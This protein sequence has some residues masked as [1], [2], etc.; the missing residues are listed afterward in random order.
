MKI[1]CAFIWFFK[2][3]SMLQVRV[4]IFSPVKLVQS[5]ELIPLRLNF[6]FF[7]SL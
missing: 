3:L 4:L 2:Y 7:F 6:G 5:L 1:I